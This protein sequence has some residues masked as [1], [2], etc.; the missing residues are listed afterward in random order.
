MDLARIYLGLGKPRQARALLSQRAARGH[1]PLRRDGGASERASA[2]PGTSNARKP[3]QYRSPAAGRVLPSGEGATRRA[4]LRSLSA[5]VAFALDEPTRVAR[6]IGRREDARALALGAWVSWRAGRYR[7]AIARAARAI[8][9]DPKQELAVQ[10]QVASALAANEPELAESLL[11]GAVALLGIDVWTL[12]F[13]EGVLAVRAGKLASA[14]RA[15]QRAALR[16]P[17]CAAPRKNLRVLREALGIAPISP[18]APVA[19]RLPTP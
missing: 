4:Q 3:P 6:L 15:F 2:P 5:E 18:I 9:L 10:V 19:P 8:R 13:A 1:R 17:T 14:E 11:R 7:R 16:C 12:S